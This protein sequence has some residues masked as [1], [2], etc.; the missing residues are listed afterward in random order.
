M[1]EARLVFN[2]YH[3]SFAPN[4]SILNTLLLGFKEV[5]DL[6][7]LN[8]F[9][10]EMIVRGFEPDVVSFNIRIDACCKK[11][12]FLD[13][14]TVF[15]EMSKR[16]LS[17]TL[18]TLTTLVYGAGIAGD[19]PK[20]QEL[21]DEMFE[22]GL[23]VDRGAYN[24]LMSCHM[25]VGN[26]KGGMAVMDEMVEKGIELDDVSYYT[27]LS[28][29]KKLEDVCLVYGRMIS[30]RFV[31]RMRTVM[32]LMKV[33]CNNKR[34]DLGL[35]FWD[36][37]VEKGLCLHCHVLDVLVIGLCGGGREDEGYRC[38]KQVVQSGR[39]PLDRTYR[40]LE[41]LLVKADEFKKL[42]ELRD[43]MSRFMDLDT[44]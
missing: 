40:L 4:S 20:A 41:G 18:Q 32:L 7:A 12:R 29:L 15:D 44:K 26:L 14:L 9:Y 25:R 22:R 5:G 31:P 34:L 35:Q 6:T 13:A 21:F 2:R 38:F 24:A 3:A 10:N 37:I 36:Y 43:M 16:N 42:E 30:N 27:V 39:Q 28:R 11:G 19:L 17:P 23:D 33:F 8:L 1:G